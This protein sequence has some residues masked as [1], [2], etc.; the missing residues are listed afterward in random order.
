MLVFAKVRGGGAAMNAV[1]ME[2]IR[3]DA[4]VV[5][6]SVPWSS[7]NGALKYFRD[8][9]IQDVAGM[10][11]ELALDR[12]ADVRTVEHGVKQNYT[13]GGWSTWDWRTFILALRPEE[14]TAVV[15][16]GI[17]AVRVQRRPGSYDHHMA[18]AARE[19]GWQHHV[20]E[21]VD[22]AFARAD[23]TTVLVH[24]RWRRKGKL[25]VIQL[26]ADSAAV[27]MVPEKGPGRS[28]GPGTYKRITSAA[29][30]DAA[31]ARPAAPVVT[32]QPAA[33]ADPKAAAPKAAAPGPPKAVA[34]G[35]PY[36]MPPGAFRQPAAH[37]VAVEPAT[38]AGWQVPRGGGAAAASGS[39]GWAAASSWNHGTA[40]SYGWAA[41]PSGWS[42]APTQSSW[43]SESAGAGDSSRSWR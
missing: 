38:A 7:H 27:R 39:D 37:A 17:T 21:I 32:G 36:P 24:P 26:P 43:W 19:H 30:S 11:V 6:A 23:G 8:Q 5:T 18:V 33:A 35:P 14:Q 42:D 12:P 13:F 9:V 28:D 22:F 29:Y 31:F 1:T 4:A 34:P 40:A 25:E 16:A 2:L 41:K 15:G 3:A 10:P 20:E